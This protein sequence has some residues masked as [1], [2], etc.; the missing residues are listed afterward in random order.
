MQADLPEIDLQIAKCVENVVELV[1][2][3]LQ[4]AE[5]SKSTRKRLGQSWY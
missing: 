3:V 1:D 2:F 4:F 5:K